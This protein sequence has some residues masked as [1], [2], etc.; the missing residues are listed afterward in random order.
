PLEGWP[1]G[2]NQQANADCYRAQT[3]QSPEHYF[4][5]SSH[6][7]MIPA[8]APGLQYSTL[9]SLSPPSQAASCGRPAGCDDPPLLAPGRL[10]EVCIR[11]RRQRARTPGSTPLLIDPESA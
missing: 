8:V 11:A 4:C 6:A 2:V 10:S 5:C 3:N 1:V 9:Q 7:A